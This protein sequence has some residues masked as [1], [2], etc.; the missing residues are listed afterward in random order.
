[1]TPDRPTPTLLTPLA[2]LDAAVPSLEREGARE[3]DG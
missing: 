2:T 3:G 1:M